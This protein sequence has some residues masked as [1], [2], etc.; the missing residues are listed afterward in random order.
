MPVLVA[1]ADTPVGVPLV[2]AL[3]EDGAEVRAY[4]TGDGDV[5]SL[6]AAGAFVA[7]GDLDDEGRL[8]AAMTDAHTVI[9][10]H[11]DPL[12]PDARVLD[13][14]LRV[15]LTAAR[16]AE[17]QRVVVRSVPRAPDG[18]DPLRRVCAAVEHAL[19]ELAVPTMAVRTSLVDTTALHDALASISPR[20]VDPD[21]PVAPITVGDVVEALVALDAVRGTARVGHATFRL[22]GR[23][24]TLHD[25]LDHVGSSGDL[26]GRVYTPGARVPL[27]GPALATPWVEAEDETVADLLAFADLRPT[28]LGPQ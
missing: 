23:A 17:V 15:L 20:D 22:Q 9:A 4:A 18:N 12:V 2:Q 1:P 7:V 28:P 16:K 27:L 11:A 26:V 13:D 8:D 24:R 25:Y 5:P 21:L 10:L 14:H 6:R 3:R 19:A